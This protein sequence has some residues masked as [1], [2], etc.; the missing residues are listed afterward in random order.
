MNHSTKI[1]LLY[2]L[3][4][5]LDV[6][7]VTLLNI[8]LP[9]IASAFQ[10]PFEEIKIVVTAFIW[11]LTLMIPLAGWL[12][13]RFGDKQI[14]IG[15][16]LLFAAASIGCFF[17]QSLYQLVILRTIQGFGGGLMTPVGMAILMKM[18]SAKERAGATAKLS[19][20]IRLAPALGPI[21]GGFTLTCLGWRWLFLLK[22]PI[23]GLCL[24]ASFLWL[25]PGHEAQEIKKFDFKG[26]L[27][28]S[29]CLGSLLMSMSSTMSIQMCLWMG[30]GIISFLLFIK[31]EK[32]AVEPII[33]LRLF[34]YKLFSQSN[35]LQC[36]AYCILLGSSFLFSIFFQESLKFDPMVTGWVLA[37]A[38]IGMLLAIPIVSLSYNRIGPKPLVIVGFLLLGSSLAAIANL[39]ALS[40]PWLAAFFIAT[41]GTGNSMIIST[42]ATSVFAEI[43]KEFMGSASSVY[44][45]TRQVA[46][47]F[48]VA[49]SSTLLA[50]TAS[51]NVALILM[52]S[53]VFVGIVVGSRI[54]NKKV[55][56]VLS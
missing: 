33:P 35:L 25:K 26:L 6:V 10:V 13:Q 27:F 11:G 14:F 52:I 37:S 46:N 41:F 31:A 50:M 15:G 12:S 53:I 23:T 5:F 54:N 21:I 32:E 39:T 24:L 17:A 28:C 40:S 16:Q 30:V 9:T 34:E 44:S 7:E 38:T 56:E 55:L 43:P 47:C 22:L 18:L 48:G 2:G 45:L 29:I 4:L 36:I 42:N 3:V 20:I 8:G 1:T 19:L 51:S 49:F